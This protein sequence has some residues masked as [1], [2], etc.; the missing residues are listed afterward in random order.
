MSFQASVIPSGNAT[1]VEVPA[2]VVKALAC[3][4]DMSQGAMLFCNAGMIFYLCR[5]SAHMSLNIKNSEVYEL[6]SELARM[7]GESMTTVV[8]EALRKQREE[9]LR[10]RQKDVRTQ[11]LMATARRCAAHIVTPVKAV[12]HGAVLYDERGMPQ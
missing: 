11:A 10:Q 4:I 7:T 2:E 9:L 8:L 5:K 6:A 1:A 3:D 12:D